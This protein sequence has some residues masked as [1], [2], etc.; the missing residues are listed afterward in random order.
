MKD[1]Q[2]H[3]HDDVEETVRESMIPLAFIGEEVYIMQ[4]DR[5]V[6][7]GSRKAASNFMEMN[8]GQY[9]SALTI[10]KSTK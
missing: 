4:Q 6:F 2:F 3:C 9:C 10:L 8:Q 5:I 1:L 7:I